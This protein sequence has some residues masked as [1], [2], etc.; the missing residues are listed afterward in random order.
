MKSWSMR[1][2]RLVRRQTGQL[3][4]EQFLLQARIVELRVRVGQFHPTD[5]HTAS[6]N[7]SAMSVSPRFLLVSG[8]I[9]AG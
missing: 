4:A 7:R 6:S 2:H 1:G 8:Q 9:E 5:M 3:R